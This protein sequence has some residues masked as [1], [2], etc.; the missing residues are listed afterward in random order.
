MGHQFL[1]GV[2][3]HDVVRVQVVSDG[4]SSPV[5][6]EGRQVRLE[7]SEKTRVDGHDMIEGTVHGLS[8]NEVLDEM[9]LITPRLGEVFR[10][11][12][13]PMERQGLGAQI[14]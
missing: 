12:R 14:L 3:L 7:M 4:P 13:C 11:L 2:E 6:V 5:E 8:A 9:L 1:A 10:Q